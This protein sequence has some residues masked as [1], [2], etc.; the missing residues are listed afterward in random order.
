LK[1]AVKL[2]GRHTGRAGNVQDAKRFRL[3]PRKM[4][5]DQARS[6]VHTMGARGFEDSAPEAQ[7]GQIPRFHLEIGLCSGF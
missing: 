5:N 7:R 6:I 2:N 3:S 4:A 1:R